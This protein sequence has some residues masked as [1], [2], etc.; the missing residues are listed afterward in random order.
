MNQESCT[1]YAPEVKETGIV[2][3]DSTFVDQIPVGTIYKYPFT[4]T[5]L[6]TFKTAMVANMIAMGMM[7]AVVDLFKIE[8]W[9]RTVTKKSPERFRDMNLTA[10]E[11][12]YKAGQELSKE[13]VTRKPVAFDRKAPVPEC[14]RKKTKS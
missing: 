4:S 8:T 9:R 1:L 7:A 10:F 3:I 12:G 14:L 13:Q 11:L 2:I 5:A 6:D